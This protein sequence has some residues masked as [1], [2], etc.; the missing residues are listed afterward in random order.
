MERDASDIADSPI[1]ARSPNLEIGSEV[2]QWMV[3][4]P[5]PS[6]VDTRHGIVLLN[7]DC[8]TH[9]AMIESHDFVL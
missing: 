2:V 5:A 9:F 1:C 8:N 3:K 7:H 4:V 6:E